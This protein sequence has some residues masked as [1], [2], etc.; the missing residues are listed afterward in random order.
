MRWFS[1]G[2]DV[3]LT[4]NSENILSAAAIVGSSRFAA[5]VPARDLDRRVDLPKEPVSGAVRRAREV[6]GL[7]SALLES[8]GDVL[9]ILKGGQ[10]SVPREEHGIGS[11]DAIFT[12]VE[13]LIRDVV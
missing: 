12:N 6:P 2:A 9:R 3:C 4:R 11:L 1:D 13:F 7:P 10:V 5:G 8:L